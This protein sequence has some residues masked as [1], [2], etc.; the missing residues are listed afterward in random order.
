MKS[1][2]LGLDALHWSSITVTGEATL[3]HCIAAASPQSWAMASPVDRPT[4]PDMRPDN[5]NQG[6]QLVGRI[7]QPPPSRQ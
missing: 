6:W 1:Q 2:R 7:V 3:C 5:A 4:A